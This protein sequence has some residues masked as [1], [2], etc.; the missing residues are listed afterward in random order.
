[1]RRP[2][3]RKPAAKRGKLVLG[4]RPG[5]VI[6]IKTAARETIRLTVEDICDPVPG[7]TTAF[8]SFVA[9]PS[10]EIWREELVELLPPSAQSF[11]KSA[12]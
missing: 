2:H 3:V 9:P 5:Q 7:C 11:P 8:I 10:V 1:M 4:R 6:V 12:G